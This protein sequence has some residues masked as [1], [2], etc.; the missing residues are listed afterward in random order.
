VADVI[1]DAIDVP[2]LDEQDARSDLRR[3]WHIHVEGPLQ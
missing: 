2:F 1:E 3:R